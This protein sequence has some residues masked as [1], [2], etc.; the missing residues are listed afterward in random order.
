MPVVQPDREGHIR[1]RR[2]RRAAPGGEE[3]G[4]E[5][6]KGARKSISRVSE[7]QREKTNWS[8]LTSVDPLGAPVSEL[9]SHSSSS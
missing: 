9:M 7:V 5:G 3:Q 6:I 8:P 1:R 2:V 4:Q